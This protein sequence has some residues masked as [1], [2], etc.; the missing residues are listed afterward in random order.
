M[1]LNIKV[2]NTCFLVKLIKGKGNKK[3]QNTQT[4]FIQN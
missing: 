2:Y 3:K 4:I 1:Q